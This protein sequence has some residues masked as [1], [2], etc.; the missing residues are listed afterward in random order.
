VAQARAYQYEDIKTNPLSDLSA[1][2]AGRTTQG[3]Q[4]ASI[5]RIQKILYLH[6]RKRFV[7]NAVL[8]CQFKV[9]KYIVQI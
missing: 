4:L 1:A 2:V 3:Y 9:N 5:S 7:R 6:K 8:H